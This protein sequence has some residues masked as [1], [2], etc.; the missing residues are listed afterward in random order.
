MGDG[1]RSFKDFIELYKRFGFCVI[2]L[3]Y[4]AKEPLVKWREFQTRKPTEEELKRWFSREDVNIGIVCGSV[5]GNLVVLDFESR[6]AFI[7]FFGKTP[8][9][10]AEL[11]LVVKTARGYHIYFKTDR[12]IS[13][14]KIP[15]LR[16]E[17]L[18]EGSQVVAPPSL[19]P[20]GVR[21]EFIGDPWK[22]NQLQNIDDVESWVWNRAGELG[23]FRYGSEDDPPCVR[24]LLNGVDKGMR[25]ESAVRLASYWLQFKRLNP[26][27][28]LRLLEEW[29]QRNRPPLDE[30]E[31]KNV[32]KSVLKHG[33]EYGCT[34][35][36]ELGVCNDGL[37]S[38]CNLRGYFEVRSVV[39]D[40]EVITKI[41]ND[42][43]ERPIE[44]H[45]LIDFHP[46][47]GFVIGTFL[48]SKQGKLILLS[49]QPV[50]TQRNE[51]ELEETQRIK[52]K[53]RQLRNLD[54]SGGFCFDMASAIRE[55]LEKPELTKE[56]R[57]EIFQKLLEKAL[58]YWYHSDA[59]WHTL[60]ASW[61]I[62]THCYVLFNYFPILHLQG[63]RESG[64]T[65]A[66]ELLRRL[67][68]NA[69]PRNVAMREAPLFRTI[70][71]NRP[72][73]F[74]DVTKLSDRPDVVDIC[75]ACTERGGTVKR[76]VEDS[77]VVVNFNVYTPVCL[78]TRVET[79]FEAKCIRIITKKP[80]AATLRLYSRRR[81]EMEYD[82]ELDELKREVLLSVI[83]SWREVKEAYDEIEQTD[84]LYG[85][86]FDYWRPFLA[87]CKVYAPDRYDELLSL[88]EDYALM[89]SEIDL[90][91]EIEDEVLR[92]LSDNPSDK[93]LL[94]DLTTYVAAK[95]PHQKITWQRVR[96]AVSNLGV[97]TKYYNSKEGLTIYIDKAKVGEKAKE[98]FTEDEEE[99]SPE[100][101][102]Q[103]SRSGSPSL[104]DI[105]ALLEATKRYR[106]DYWLAS[107]IEDD[108]AK[109][110]G[111]DFWHVIKLLSSREW[112]ET[113]PRVWLEEHPRIRG[114]FR[115][116]VR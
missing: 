26:R 16:L 70:E 34:G 3:K 14:F 50:L 61:V 76:C 43:F 69:T 95:F 96:S 66:Q 93:I 80:D 113:N 94:K 86:I 88:A 30:K 44:I 17:V 37:K 71:D 22:L 5:S 105:Q 107:D 19:H 24:R 41:L 89:H 67:A 9:E 7:R 84:K 106:G 4:G 27:K 68:R 114:V 78:A 6:E 81:R 77:N 72:T 48:R 15:E 74:I 99:V 31:L 64:K 20:T 54:D 101:C 33:Y 39:T 65:T 8:E 103:E 83:N 52:I 18:A 46:A 29:N 49:D 104:E 40:K 11:T 12:P 90:I 108:Y 1:Q 82:A 2:P 55:A 10:M 25:N 58:Y 60:L 87:I 53:L 100:T 75:E 98:R 115:L 23:V 51:I 32:F 38:I 91:S 42:G 109:A 21:Y 63:E 110:G 36:V 116:R 56:G 57:R 102:N 62:G 28:A 35:M 97:A 13:S 79:G 85:R 92:Y 45:P 112:L 73:F 47:V 111:R 59:R